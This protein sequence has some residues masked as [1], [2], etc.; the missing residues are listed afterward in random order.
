LSTGG[1]FAVVIRSF[2]RFDRSQSAF[3]DP[4]TE[5]NMD[6][7]LGKDPDYEAAD[8]SVIEKLDRILPKG[9]KAVY[10]GKTNSCCCS[11]NGLNHS[12]FLISP[13]H[14]F[15]VVKHL[16]EKSLFVVLLPGN[17]NSLLQEVKYISATNLAK[18]YVFVPYI[19]YRSPKMIKSWLKTFEVFK[20]INISLPYENVERKDCLY[21][22]SGNVMIPVT[23]KDIYQKQ[24]KECATPLNEV[25]QNLIDSKFINSDY[26]QECQLNYPHIDFE[27]KG[28]LSEIFKDV[29][30]EYKSVNAGFASSQGL[31]TSSP[32]PKIVRKNSLS[33]RLTPGANLDQAQVGD[34]N[35]ETF[36]TMLLIA[37]V[38]VI[39]MFAAAWLET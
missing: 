15:E 23:L 35:E 19:D 37:L 10:V 12:L 34:F 18:A 28:Q 5:K 31:E 26:K 8:A 3:D 32:G 7:Y 36:G 4:S 2:E 24:N 29:H 22:I 13:D 17:T 16:I 11:I 21:Q 30:I 20:N 38:I 39:V 6:D 1:P 14:W 27:K 25:L 33:H 9:L